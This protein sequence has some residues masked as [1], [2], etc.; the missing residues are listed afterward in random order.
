MSGKKPRKVLTDM[1]HGIKNNGIKRLARRGGVKRIS[2]LVYE[3]MR[4]EIKRFLKELLK[5]CHTYA[6]HSRRKRIIV[7]DVLFALKLQNMTLL[8]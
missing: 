1:E 3:T 2:S 7:Q 8:V 4:N 5:N 6:E